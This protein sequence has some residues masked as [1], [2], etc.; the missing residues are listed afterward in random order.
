MLKW[1]YF[2]KFGL[3]EKHKN[4]CALFLMLWTFTQKHEEDFFKFCVFLKKSEF[5]LAYS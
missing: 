3:P 5:N 4:I 1:T 2:V